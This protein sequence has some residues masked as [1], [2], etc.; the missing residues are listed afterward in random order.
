MSFNTVGEGKQ[1]YSEGKQQ[2]RRGSIDMGSHMWS[3]VGS[4]KGS[5]I[6]GGSMSVSFNGTRGSRFG[7]GGGD[8]GARHGAAMAA[9]AASGKLQSHAE[10]HECVSLA[11][12]YIVGF[13]G[14]P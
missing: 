6:R 11:F 12:I 4:P 2:Y 3:H 10:N 9:A 8:G 14:F 13:G 7:G 1:Q 5:S